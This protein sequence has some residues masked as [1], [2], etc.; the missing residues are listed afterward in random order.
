MV[1]MYTRVLMGH[2]DLARAVFPNGT[3]DVLMDFAAR[4]PQ[5]EIGR[6][7]G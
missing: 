5:Y 7:Y 6:D 3:T 4:Q 1:E 2:V